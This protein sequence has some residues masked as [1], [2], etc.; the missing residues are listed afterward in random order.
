[1]CAGGA[2]SP[3]GGPLG[4]GLE[5][6]LWSR[7]SPAIVML[8][9]VE[10]A[11]LLDIEKKILASG[12]MKFSFSFN[13]STRGREATRLDLDLDARSSQDEGTKNTDFAP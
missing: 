11:M 7:V 8:F 4:V 3:G 10:I 9:N 6:L 5:E 2:F 13:T 12:K 1:M